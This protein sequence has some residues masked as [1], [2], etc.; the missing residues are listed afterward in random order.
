MGKT[1]LYRLISQGKFPRPVAVEGSRAWRS[2]D[3]EEWIKSL[4]IANLLH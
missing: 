3:V 2:T 1:K 4:P